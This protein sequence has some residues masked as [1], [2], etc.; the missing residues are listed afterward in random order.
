MNK[1]KEEIKETNQEIQ[2]KEDIDASNYLLKSE[3][4]IKKY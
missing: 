3:S 1:E 2:I 4:K